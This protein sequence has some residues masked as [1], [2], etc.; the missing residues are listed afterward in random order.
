MRESNWEE[1][2]AKES[3]TRVTGWHIQRGTKKRRNEREKVSS[4]V[5][6]TQLVYIDQRSQKKHPQ[7]TALKRKKTARFYLQGER[8]LESRRA[9]FLSRPLSRSPRR[10]SL[11][12]LEDAVG[13]LLLPLCSPMMAACYTLTNVRDGLISK[14]LLLTVSP[15]HVGWEDD[16]FVVPWKC[17]P[18]FDGFLVCF[19]PLCW[20]SVFSLMSFLLVADSWLLFLV[21]GRWWCEWGRIRKRRT[22]FQVSSRFFLYGAEVNSPRDV[23]RKKRRVP[24]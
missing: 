7:S 23:S 9:S 8:D 12:S 24:C 17:V 13:L 6:R 3:E 4:P 2:R 10:S 15:V 11:R 16:L 22:I 5:T 18:Y 21:L 20:C 19:R 14:L 1:I